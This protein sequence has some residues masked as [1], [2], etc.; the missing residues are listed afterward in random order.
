MLESLKTRRTPAIKAS[1]QY[2]LL[3]EKRKI[4][5]VGTL[6]TIFT[7]S[8]HTSDRQVYSSEPIMKSNFK[9]LGKKKTC[10]YAPKLSRLHS[11]FPRQ[12]ISLHWST[13]K[14]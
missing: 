3:Q 12:G 14:C 10:S 5:K 7:N 9:T 1:W 13:V 4:V 11:A 6:E 8:L 2:E